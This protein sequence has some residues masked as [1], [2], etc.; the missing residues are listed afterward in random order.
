MSNPNG[1]SPKSNRNPKSL[2]G[3][4]GSESGRKTVGQRHG[5]MGAGKKKFGPG[6]GKNQ[7]DGLGA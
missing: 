2:P 6:T 4:S 7:G 5:A 1:T 3:K